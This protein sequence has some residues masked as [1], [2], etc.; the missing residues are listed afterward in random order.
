MRISH[1]YKFVFVSVPRTGSTSLR[2]HLN[3]Y[4]DIIS[5]DTLPYMHHARAH[6]IREEFKKNGWPWDNYFKFAFIRNPWDIEV[7]WYHY[8]KPDKRLKTIFNKGEYNKND[9]IKFTEWIKKRNLN[10]IPSR[11]GLQLDYLMDD[12]GAFI[13]DFVGKFENLKK[14][15]ISICNRIGIPFGLP[16]IHGTKHMHY[17]GYYTK[18]TEE[19]IAKWYKNEI[20]I[21]KY[22]FEKSGV[23]KN[24]AYA[25]RKSILDTAG[26]IDY[27]RRSSWSKHYFRV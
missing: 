22:R 16:R 1:R 24:V 12:N 3:A 9:P 10:H 4:S 25:A 17:S 13:V 14:D 2:Q 11:F 7:S 20:E 21:F 8:S 26:L 5:A 27:S 6:D 18:E 19:I 23:I 15:Y